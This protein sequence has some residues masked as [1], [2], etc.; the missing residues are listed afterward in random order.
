M[1]A[2]D[3]RESSRRCSLL[4]LSVVYHFGVNVMLRW[5]KPCFIWCTPR[6]AAAAA[7]IHS[8]TYIV[9]HLDWCGP[10]AHMAP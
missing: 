8:G 9:W 5:G 6:A 3:G 7:Y 1:T 2:D 10:I 4:I